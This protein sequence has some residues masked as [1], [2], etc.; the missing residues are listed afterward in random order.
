MPKNVESNIRNV[1]FYPKDLDEIAGNIQESLQPAWLSAG[2]GY[3]SA[4]KSQM[5]MCLFSR[6]EGFCTYLKRCIL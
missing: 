3:T 5:G 1:G 6:V 4:E 2:L